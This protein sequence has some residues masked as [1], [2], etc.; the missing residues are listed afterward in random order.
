MPICT[1]LSPDQHTEP[2]QHEELNKILKE[3][4][5][6]SGKDWRVAEH[7]FERSHWFRKSE[8]VYR[9]ELMLHICSGEFQCI[10]FHRDDSNW[11]INTTVPAELVIAFLYGIL[12]GRTMGGFTEKVAA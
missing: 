10:N 2:T 5:Q 7:T 3:V 6:H 12:A 1:Y 4:R 8:V 9:Y 11:S